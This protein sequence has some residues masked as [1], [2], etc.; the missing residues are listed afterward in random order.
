[1]EFPEKI[2]QQVLADMA[3]A[4]NYQ[5]FKHLRKMQ[6]DISWTQE[7]YVTLLLDNIGY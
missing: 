7:Q 6:A 4:E 2:T 1:M 3:Y 5:E